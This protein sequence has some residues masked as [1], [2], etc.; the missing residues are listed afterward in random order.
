MLLHISAS[1]GHV[2]HTHPSLQPLAGHLLPPPRRP[3]TPSHTSNTIRH[4]P[5]RRA[6]PPA[7]RQTA[8]KA[9]PPTSMNAPHNIPALKTHFYQRKTSPARCQT[10]RGLIFAHI[11]THSLVLGLGRQYGRGGQPSRIDGSPRNWVVWVGLEGDSI[12]ACT[13]DST[14]KAK[15]MRREPR[16]AL[17]VTDMNNPYRMAAIQGRSEV[18]SDEGCR[19][20]DPISLKYTR[21]PSPSVEGPDRVCSSSPSRKRHSGRFASCTIRLE[22]LCSE[23]FFR[24]RE[25]GDPCRRGTGPPP[26]IA[27]A[28][29]RR[30]RHRLRKRGTELRP[31]RTPGHPG[32][33]GQRK[34]VSGV[35]TVRLLSANAPR[36]GVSDRSTP[37]RRLAQRQLSPTRCSRRL[38]PV[39]PAGHSWCDAPV[40]STS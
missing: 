28:T 30:S 13:S 14:W 1:C 34:A 7:P 22:R 8:Q 23:G 21:A 40:L 17:S 18:R 4:P 24:D 39:C 2:T 29:M 36:S 15:D 12:L 27:S 32:I 33:R 19:F 3:L 16:V 9:S 38:R 6:G 26:V 5:S 37:H 10:S 20:M 35:S 11:S 25:T 31:A